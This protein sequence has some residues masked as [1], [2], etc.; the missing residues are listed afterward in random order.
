MLTDQILCTGRY[1][2]RTKSRTCTVV[3]TCSLYKKYVTALSLTIVYIKSATG[4]SKYV[5]V[6][7]SLKKNYCNFLRFLE[8]E[9][10]NIRR[11][12]SGWRKNLQRKSFARNSCYFKKLKKKPPHRGCWTKYSL[13]N[14]VSKFRCRPG[15]PT[16]SSLAFPRILTLALVYTTV[17]YII[18]FTERERGSEKKLP[19]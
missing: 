8:H 6:G 3:L 7:L 11:C 16:S 12:S 19:Y 5:Y 17:S 2:S 4:R 10:E 15:L 18:M 13:S 1:C 14:H 9:L